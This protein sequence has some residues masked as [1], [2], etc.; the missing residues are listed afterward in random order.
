MLGDEVAEEP[1]SEAIR[2]YLEELELDLVQAARGTGWLMRSGVADGPA[3]VAIA[4]EFRGGKAPVAAGSA[5]ANTD[6]L[7]PG[8]I[9]A[10]LGREPKIE[11]TI[12][13]DEVARTGAVTTAIDDLAK[14]RPAVLLREFNRRAFP[15]QPLRRRFAIVLAGPAANLLFAPLL[16]AVTF[17]VGFPTPLPILGAVDP[18][19]P[20][21]AA[22]LREGDRV[23]AVDSAPI[24]TWED[25][26]R[27]VRGSAGR[28][29]DLR[30]KRTEGGAS[31][32]LDL[33]VRP[34]LI[35]TESQYGDKEPTWVVG[36]RASGVEEMRKL[37]LPRA[38][39]EGFAQSARMA[40]T[41]CIAIGKI[42]DGST[43][44][45]EALGG[46][47]MI[48]RIAG[49]EVHRGFADV[50]MFMVTVSLELGIINLLPVPLL[51]GGHL[52]FFAI[53]GIRGEPLKLRHREIAMQVGL[54]LLVV[55]MAFVIFNDI[56]RLIG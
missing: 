18:G 31:R 3:L 39:Y 25:F 54:F 29:L 12:L 38:V 10:V 48:A 32:L 20:G 2:G 5:E 50:A 15:S 1:S 23:V 43:P 16:T 33:R 52:L 41:L 8:N 40:G 44:A 7:P 46:P 14:A 28:E 4:Q 42:I 27:V 56:S 45:R 22:G 47:I 55:L 17:M 51:D 36:V 26:S 13:L 53:E 37:P 21:Y 9:V 49:K 24:D 30:V 34:R 11:E 6:S 35:E 19:L